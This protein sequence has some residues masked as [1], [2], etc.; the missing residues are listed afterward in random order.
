MPIKKISDKITPN[1]SEIKRQLPKVVKDSYKKFVEVTP[2]D[3]GNARNRTR[4]IGN[5]ISADYPY[6][7]RLEKGYSKKAPQGMVAPTIKFL[8]N[9]LA[10][11][12]R[13]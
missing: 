6:A 9:L 12:I 1:L 7:R 13:K 11:T 10:R 5:T 2:K 3:S 8:K 4:L